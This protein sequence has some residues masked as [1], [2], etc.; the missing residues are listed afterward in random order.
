MRGVSD[1]GLRHDLANAQTSLHLLRRMLEKGELE[2]VQRAW[3]Q[4]Q[5]ALLEEQVRS[6]QHRLDAE[7]EDL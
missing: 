6:L 3:A 5:V 7:E 2:P 4:E 1:K